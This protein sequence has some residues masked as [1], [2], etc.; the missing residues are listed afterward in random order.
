[1]DDRL[2]LIKSRTLIQKYKMQQSILMAVEQ[3]NNHRNIVYIAGTYGPSQDSKHSQNYSEPEP[4]HTHDLA[5][6][7]LRAQGPSNSPGND[8]LSPPPSYEEA[9]SSQKDIRPS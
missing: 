5:S 1:M 4:V 7:I 2:Q 6:G 3:D 9:I 8:E